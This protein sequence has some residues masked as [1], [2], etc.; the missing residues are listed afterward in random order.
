MKAMLI[1]VV[2]LL[3]FSISKA[4]DPKP[5][6]PKQEEVK[7]PQICWE[8]IELYDDKDF[9]KKMDENSDMMKRYRKKLPKYQKRVKEETAAEFEKKGM[10]LVE[11]PDH[12]T[13]G[14]NLKQV[15]KEDKPLHLRVS[16]AYDGIIEITVY[17]RV[18][19]FRGDKKV[20]EFKRQKSAYIWQV[21]TRAKYQAAI[22]AFAREVV[23]GLGDEVKKLEPE[24]KKEEGK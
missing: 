6:E 7:K 4:E 16:L 22:Y 17:A 11:C 13:P 3:G 12:K 10:E 1:A 23:S 20:I 8:S 19:V 2:C 9:K 24:E 15:T 18:E 21:A 5:E 14:V